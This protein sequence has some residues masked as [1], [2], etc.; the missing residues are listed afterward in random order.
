MLE[1]R[2]FGRVSSSARGSFAR[3]SLES[4]ESRYA[5]NGDP[6]I[7]L[8]GPPPPPMPLLTI[9]VEYG[10]GKTV[11]LSGSLS[12]VTQVGGVA[13]D[14]TGQADGITSTDSNGHYTITLTADGLGSVYA[15]AVG[16]GAQAMDYFWDIAPEITNF[17]ACE[18]EDRLWTFTGSVEYHRPFNTMAINFGGVPVSVSGGTAADS[19]GSFTWMV[20]LNGTPSDNG[21]AWA[22]AISPWG[23][24]SERAYTNIHQTGT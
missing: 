21:L 11:T 17:S 8:P 16:T 6:F 7:G 13:I 12:G 10:W 4:L 1:L 19:S 9:E 18:G 15:L 22:E 14:I 20:R 24:V 2:S 3:P 23:L 5:L